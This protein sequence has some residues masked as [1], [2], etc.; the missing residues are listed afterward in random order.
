ME[1]SKKDLDRPLN[2]AHWDRLAAILDSPDMRAELDLEGLD[3]LIAANACGPRDTPP[4]QVFAA[5]FEG[6]EFPDFASAKDGGDF[7]S[8]ALRR[9][10]EYVRF[11]GLERGQLTVENILVPT[12]LEVSEDAVATALEWTP[13]AAA[14]SEGVR[15]PG[16]WQGQAWARGFMRAHLAY[17]ESWIPFDRSE[18]GPLRLAPLMLLD[19]GY[20]PDH[21]EQKLDT[22]TWITM[23][24]LMVRDIDAFFREQFVR[25]NR[26]RAT[27]RAPPKVGRNDS[28]PCGGG[29]KYKRCCGAAA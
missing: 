7:V 5:A 16:R 27:Y 29:R 6:G 1:L 21:P 20:N 22:E 17:P 23:L 8:L 12:L 11:C 13:D 18:D 10:N 14:A 19:V 25:Q 2:D 4:M 9:M 15:R 3:G 28:C 24:P 26:T